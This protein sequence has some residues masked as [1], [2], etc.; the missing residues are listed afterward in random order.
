MV[1]FGTQLNEY[2]NG[3]GIYDSIL[4]ASVLL[5]ITTTAFNY[6]G[7]HLNPHFCCLSFFGSLQLSDAVSRGKIDFHAI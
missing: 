4:Q 1:N 2:N 6:S 7:S 5:E 3:S